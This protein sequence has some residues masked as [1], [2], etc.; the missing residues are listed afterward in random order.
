M[1]KKIFKWVCPN[2]GKYISSM[3]EKQFAFNKGVHI[4]TCKKAKENIK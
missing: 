4:K 1:S 3:Y 2:C